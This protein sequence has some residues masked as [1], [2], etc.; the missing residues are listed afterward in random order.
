MTGQTWIFLS[1]TYDVTTYQCICMKI[2]YLNPIK[3]VLAQFV[4]PFTLIKFRTEPEIQWAELA[5]IGLV[6]TKIYNMYFQH[7]I[8]EL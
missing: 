1:V 5:E 8:N 7:V 2:I 3:L 6:T 4:K